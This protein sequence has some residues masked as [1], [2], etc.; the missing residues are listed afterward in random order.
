MGPL[1]ASKVMSGSFGFL[2]HEGEWMTNITQFQGIPQINKEEIQRAGTR[3]VGHKAVS[4]VGSGSMTGFKM[5]NTLAKKI[6]KFA[7]D[8]SPMFVTELIGKLDDPDAPESKQ[9]V[10]YKG[11]QFDS[12][13]LLQY[14]VGSIVTEEIPFTYS[15]I[16]FLD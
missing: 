8:K 15:G 9:R 3:W 5:T 1:D 12:I 14:E 11:V 4:I 16:E 10:R 6:A 7:D 13:P 2:Y